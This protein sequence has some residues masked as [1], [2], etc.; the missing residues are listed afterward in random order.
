MDKLQKYKKIRFR[1][2]IVASLTAMVIGSKI[3]AYLGI[4]RSKLISLDTALSLA[5]IAVI[6]FVLD[7]VSV[8]IADNWYKK[9]TN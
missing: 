5:I 3:S 7:K 1:L 4:G 9:Q 2:G 8:R 6:A